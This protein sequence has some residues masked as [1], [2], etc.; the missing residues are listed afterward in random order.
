M[1]RAEYNKLVESNPD[2]V[3]SV[4]RH[5][6]F[7]AREVAETE[8]FVSDFKTFVSTSKS[9]NRPLLTKNMV[10]NFLLSDEY[11]KKY[12]PKPFKC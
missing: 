2:I 11:N 5:L 12:K 1:T 7:E 8:G 6:L 3:Q 10:F 4:I 9:D